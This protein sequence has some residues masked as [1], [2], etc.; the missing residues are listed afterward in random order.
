MK[1]LFLLLLLPP[2]TYGMEIPD[3]ALITKEPVKLLHDKTHFY[4]SDENASYRVQNH[5]ISPLLKQVLKRNALAE[6]SRSCKIRVKKHKDGT[7]S[8][9]DKVTGKGGGPVLAGFMYGTVKVLA[10][11]GMAVMG[12]GA[13]V[14]VTAATGGTATPL[15]AGAGVLAKGAVAA[16]TAQA[17]I[18]TALAGTAVGTAAGAG[19]TALVATAGTAGALGFIEAAA[20]WAWGLGMAAPTI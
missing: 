3:H 15:L 12:T 9:V 5:E 19:T 4:V 11:T 1:K 17:A 10:Y 14:T 13:V 7:Y 6:Y 2:F 20:L 16:T 18:G 8:L